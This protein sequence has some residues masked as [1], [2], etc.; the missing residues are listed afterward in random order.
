MSRRSAAG[1]R[2]IGQAGDSA[3]R[4]KSGATKRGERRAGLGRGSG[5]PG[6]VHGSTRSGQSGRERRHA[7]LITPS[8]PIVIIGA[9][10][11]VHDAHLP[12]YRQAG[13]PVAGICDLDAAKA[14]ALARQFAIP[15]VYST[16]AEAVR[17]A[18]PEAVFD[19][20]VPAPALQAVVA[21]LPAGR[22]AL[23]QKPLGESLAQAQAIAALCRRRQLR[24]AVNF[25]LRYAPNVLAARDLLAGGALGQLHA[26][27]ARVNVHMPWGLWTFLARHPR[28]EVLYHSIHYLDLIRGFLGDPRGVYAKTIRH[29]A[30]PDMG[31]TRS[32]IILDYGDQFLATVTATHHNVFGPERQESFIR[33]EATRGMIIAQM[34]LNLDYPAGR[35]DTLEYA[36]VEGDP[37]SGSAQA[38]PV[39]HS[40]PLAGNW[41]P[42]AF[43]GTMASVMRWADDANAPAPTAVEDAVK[44]MAV[45]EAAYASSAAGGHPLDLAER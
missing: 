31:P 26:M 44:T 29:P 27:E 40:V 17:A 36:V 37:A 9:G 6:G 13:F 43:I 2:P 25:Q 5:G 24:A 10:G 3:P 12:A 38:K 8:R 14:A 30:T 1:A 7:T 18:P 23:L 41:I 11:I 34:G 45:V 33:W 21:E 15:R 19:V 42:N 20:A 28:V 22:A 32:A 16:L 35:P 4:A 39:W